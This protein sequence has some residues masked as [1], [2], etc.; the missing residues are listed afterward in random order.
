MKIIETNLP[1]VLILE[2]D[3]FRDERG[4]FLETYHYD[5]YRENGVA[6]TFVQDNVSFSV[7]GTLR[8][9]HYQYPHAQAK[10]VQVLQGEI[11]DVALDIRKGSPTFGSWTGVSLSG[12]THRQLYIPEGFAHGFAVMS[13]TAM[14]TYKCSDV[15]TPAAEGGICWNDTD[16]NID[17]PVDEPV[18]SEKDRHYP[19][20]RDVPPDSLPLYGG[21]S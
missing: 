14:F 4:F 11:F 7:K 17:W 20:L 5:R 9:L 16:L 21:S 12:E 18:L 8:G 6:S 3:V 10:L 2:P 15:Y 19:P 1:G 13:E